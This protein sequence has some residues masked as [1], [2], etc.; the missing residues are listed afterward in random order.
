LAEYL[1]ARSL[2]LDG[3]LEEQARQ[4]S[5]P[6]VGGSARDLPVDAAF[7]AGAPAVRQAAYDRS[8]LAVRSA[9]ELVGRPAVT[10]WYRTWS[11]SGSRSAPAG[12]PMS[13]VLGRYRAAL[14]DWRA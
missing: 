13:A 5:G 8:W 6:G 10:R 1:S 7:V 3:R 12:V 2:G 11:V 14:R 4:R 9:V